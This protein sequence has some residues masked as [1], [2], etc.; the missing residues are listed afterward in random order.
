LKQGSITSPSPALM[1]NAG[2]VKVKG[3]LA[4]EGRIDPEK[5]LVA[6]LQ[7]GARIHQKET[8]ESQVA[9]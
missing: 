9:L 2:D 4:P 6:L 8:I 7:R 3:M 1:L 5:F